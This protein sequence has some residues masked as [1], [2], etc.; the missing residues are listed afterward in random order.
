MVWEGEGEGE[1][2]GFREPD[3]GHG[4]SHCVPLNVAAHSSIPYEYTNTLIT[5]ASHAPHMR[6]TC[7]AQ[8]AAQSAPLKP[9]TRQYHINT[10]SCVPLMRPRFPFLPYG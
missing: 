2:E 10:C 8:S 7:A 9:R 5:C 4:E 3:A 6:L 1:G